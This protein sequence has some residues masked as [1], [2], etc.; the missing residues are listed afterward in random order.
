MALVLFYDNIFGKKKTQQNK[1]PK[2][3]RTRTTEL[4]IDSFPY[5][6][7]VSQRI[8]VKKTNEAWLLSI[9]K[10]QQNKQ[11]QKNFLVI[12][13]PK[14]SIRQNSHCIERNMFLLHKHQ[15]WDMTIRA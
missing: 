10:T 2:S 5:E 13:K 6:I 3:F 4:V 1:Q 12:L 8:S 11:T 9:K 7:L 15:E 14:S